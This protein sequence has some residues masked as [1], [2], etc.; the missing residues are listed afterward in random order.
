MYV[1]HID[2]LV[3]GKLIKTSINTDVLG[4][5]VFHGHMLDM[6][7]SGWDYVRES[8]GGEEEMVNRW[9]LNSECRMIMVGVEMGVERGYC[10]GRNE[11]MV[12]MCGMAR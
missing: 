4:E 8:S 12:D 11:E 7:V 5:S 2:Q 10:G 1:R 3:N 9:G 6:E